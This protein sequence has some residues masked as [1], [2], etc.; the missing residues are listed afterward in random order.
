MDG[1]RR[2]SSL[3]ENR[4]FAVAPG[5]QGTWI[6]CACGVSRRAM[7]CGRLQCIDRGLAVPTDR[8]DRPGFDLA[9]MRAE[10]DTRLQRLQQELESV[11]LPIARSPSEKLRVKHA[12]SSAGSA[13]APVADGG[14]ASEAHPPT[15]RSTAS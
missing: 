10:M 4:R 3:K 5:G 15:S 11:A 13:P 8:D 2:Q 14:G 1:C 9:T 12:G 7:A 6:D